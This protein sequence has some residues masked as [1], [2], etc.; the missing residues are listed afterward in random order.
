MKAAYF[1]TAAI[2]IAIILL[3]VFFYHINYNNQNT[4]EKE[5][6][7]WVYVGYAVVGLI[8]FGI[9]VYLLLHKSSRVLYRGGADDEVK[10]IDF[11][12]Y[13]EHKPI[14][15][16]VVI[17]KLNL[18]KE[19]FAKTKLEKVQELFYLSLII[20]IEDDISKFSAT[21]IFEELESVTK[22]DFST[23]KN[24]FIYEKSLDNIYRELDNCLVKILE[25]GPL[26]NDNL[27]LIKAY[28]NEIY[29]FSGRK[30][31][32]WA[33]PFLIDLHE[34]DY[35][36]IWT[37]IISLKDANFE[38]FNEKRFP[39]FCGKI[40]RYKPNF[41]RFD[42]ISK[43]FNL[44]SLPLDIIVQSIFI[45]MKYCSSSLEHTY[46]ST[47]PI[48][49]YID[50]YSSYMN[51]LNFD[52]ASLLAHGITE[53]K[54][55]NII[56]YKNDMIEEFGKINE[57]YKRANDLLKKGYDSI[58]YILRLSGNIIDDLSQIEIMM[59]DNTLFGKQ[60][61]QE[62]I[63]ITVSRKK[64]L[65]EHYSIVNK[66][67]EEL[68]MITFLSKNNPDIYFFNK[69]YVKI[70]EIYNERMKDLDRYFKIVKSYQSKWP[71]M[72]GF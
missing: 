11:S 8:M 10:E 34:K 14:I 39:L 60:K 4:T 54:A 12:L 46:F 32:G 27:S 61:Y 16:P 57:K 30:N 5:S 71:A 51:Y 65:I 18:F 17:D 53:S 6:S 45:I 7:M 26:D 42:I 3:S 41:Y 25:S 37:A 50:D 62:N 33:F 69:E 72:H 20:N 43:N 13:K 49:V 1:S 35:T 19:Y 47:Q 24:L 68:K 22:K 59:N 70:T 44:F 67:M 64:S 28:I 9:L 38:D 29:P 23:I 36:A 55:D 21:K 63:E 48:Y 40:I 52:K 66:V 58:R 15:Q 31:D 56:E 2:L